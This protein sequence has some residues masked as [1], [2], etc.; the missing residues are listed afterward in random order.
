M[1]IAQSTTTHL[2]IYPRD[3]QNSWYT[4]AAI[5]CKYISNK[6]LTLIL[7]VLIT[8]IMHHYITN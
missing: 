3:S 4:S 5:F 6:I 1:V 7:M 8:H 2:H